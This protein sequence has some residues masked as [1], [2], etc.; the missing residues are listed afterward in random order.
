MFAVYLITLKQLDLLVHNE[1]V[2]L[3]QVLQSWGTA[4]WHLGRWLHPL[5]LLLLGRRS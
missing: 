1:L 3:C 2:H 5:G 4:W